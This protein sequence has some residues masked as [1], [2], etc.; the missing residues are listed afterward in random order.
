MSS[1]DVFR[2]IIAALDSAAIRHMLTGS[3]AGAFHGNPRATQDIDLV[4]EADEHQVRTFIQ[5]LPTAEYYADE[6]AAL[7]ALRDETQFNIVDLASGWKIDL[8]MR[9][10]R[11]FS[12]EEFG[13]RRTV[14][15]EGTKLS[16]ATAEDLIIAKLE[17]AKRGESNRQ[18]EDVAMI[19]ELRAAELDDAYLRRWVERLGLELEWI[20]ARSD[21]G[22]A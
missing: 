10:S 2:R 21:A 7:E 8:I 5:S 22:L 14:D 20:A 4:I 11:P 15:F 3:F 9:K 17:W 18:I 12:V 1:R 16:V 13:R 6:G 19:L